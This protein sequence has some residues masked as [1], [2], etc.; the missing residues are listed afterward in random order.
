MMHTLAQPGAPTGI[1]EKTIAVIHVWLTRERNHGSGETAVGAS[2]N[3]HSFVQH[4]RETG[5]LFWHHFGADDDP[6]L[7]VT[8]MNHFYSDKE[9]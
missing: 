6:I 1:P 9:N 5:K 4:H 8:L 3:H 2:K 7:H